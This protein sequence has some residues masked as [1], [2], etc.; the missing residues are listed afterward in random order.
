MD[1]EIRSIRRKASITEDQLQ[2]C[3][4]EKHRKKEMSFDNLQLQ[5]VIFSKTL[6][7]RE[8]YSVRRQG[9]IKHIRRSYNE[10]LRKRKKELNEELKGKYRNHEIELSEDQEAWK[11]YLM[12]TKYSFLLSIKLPS[13][14]QAGFRRTKN[15]TEALTQYTRLIKLLECEIAGSFWRRFPLRFVGVYEHGKKGFWHVHLAIPSSEDDVY[16]VNELRRSIG[17]IVEQHKFF[18]TVFDLEIVYDQEGLCMYMVKELN[19]RKNLCVDEGSG[20]FYVEDLFKGV[21]RGTYIAYKALKDLKR[22]IVSGLH[23][24]RKTSYNLLKPIRYKKEKLFQK[25]FN[26]SS[27]KIYSSSDFDSS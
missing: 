5:N 18:S 2:P 24:I 3:R 19:T 21:K 16:I 10:I 6:K 15:R 23:T 9:K 14:N 4:V 13:I 27:S 20:L 1:N 22:L 26:R 12:K 11:Q 25:R 17:R 7:R 8:Y